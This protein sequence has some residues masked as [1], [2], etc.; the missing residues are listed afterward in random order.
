MGGA[1]P[2][3][4]LSPKPRGVARRPAPATT[5]E[6]QLQTER[7]PEEQTTQGARAIRERCFS[8]GIEGHMSRAC[9][10][11]KKKRQT[12]A[13][14]QR[15]GTMSALTTNKREVQKKIENLRR[16]LQAAKALMAVQNSTDVLHSVLGSEDSIRG[17]LGPS[18]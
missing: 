10:Y 12:E 6:G 7:K 1:Q 13:R 8:C 5:S 11:P 4:E 17:Q 18:V 3:K 16:Q 14:G 9:P 15:E 2:A